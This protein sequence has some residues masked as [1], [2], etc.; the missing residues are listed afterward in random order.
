MA[1]KRATSPGLKASVTVAY[2]AAYKRAVSVG[3][4]ASTTVVKGWGRVIA[5]SGAGLTAA[6]SIVVTFVGGGPTDFLITVVANLTASATIG[7]A[8]AWNRATSTALSVS[9]LIAFTLNRFL[10]IFSVLATAFR[11]T[12]QQTN[13]LVITSSLDTGLQIVSTLS[14]EFT[15]TSS[16]ASA[17]VIESTLEVR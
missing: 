6:V 15:I 12:P 13:P 8:I 7:R 1:Y 3:L 16:L 5:T 9:A 11:I 14:N 17:L 2:K 10:K 4:T